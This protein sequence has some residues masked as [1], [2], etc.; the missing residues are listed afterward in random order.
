MYIFI[1]NYLIIIIK[2]NINKSLQ[3]IFLFIN[4][5]LIKVLYF[6]QKI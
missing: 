2:N 4:I 3:Y 6:Y 5:I 1:K